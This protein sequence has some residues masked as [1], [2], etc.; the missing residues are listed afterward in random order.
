[1]F[2]VYWEGTEGL[3]LLVLWLMIGGEG[4]GEVRRRSWWLWRTLRRRMAATGAGVDEVEI[5][6]VSGRLPETFDG[7]GGRC[8][9]YCVARR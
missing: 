2:I 7:C 4:G 3:V 9:G 1:M 5:G 6:V 8:E